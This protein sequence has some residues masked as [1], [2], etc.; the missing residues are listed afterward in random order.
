MKS[1]EE[2]GSRE[3]RPQ[4]GDTVTVRPILGIENYEPYDA[5]LIGFAGCGMARVKVGDIERLVMEE[6][7]KRK[8][9]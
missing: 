4:L 5:E 9:R 2:F 1:K 3:I 6:Q 7:M 8:N